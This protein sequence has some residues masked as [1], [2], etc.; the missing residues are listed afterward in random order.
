MHYWNNG[1]PK[2]LVFKRLGLQ[3]QLLGKKVI[4]NSGSP[5]VSCP[6]INDV[7]QAGRVWGEQPPSAERLLCRA[8]C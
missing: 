7:R 6:D 4:Q 1:K 3:S 8:R 2:H 5:V